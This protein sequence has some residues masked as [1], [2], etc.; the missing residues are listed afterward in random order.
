MPRLMIERPCAARALARASTSKAVSVPSTAMR[1]AISNMRIL[2]YGPAQRADTW[3]NPNRHR[4]RSEAIL[5]GRARPRAR[6]N[7]IRSKRLRFHGFGSNN[8][9]MTAND[10]SLERHSSRLKSHSHSSSPGLTRGST[11]FF[12]D[13]RA[14][15]GHDEW[16]YTFQPKW[17]SLSS[18]RAHHPL[19]FA[20]AGLS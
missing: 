10:Q 3:P 2:R 5:R 17:I 1:P 4:E 13:G 16:G 6:R 9:G 14:K 8:S 15:P 20:R 18:P 19:T 7:E 11:G 12:V